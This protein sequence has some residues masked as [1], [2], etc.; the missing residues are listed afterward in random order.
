MRRTKAE[1]AATRDSII[2]AAEH[3][4]LNQ[5][6]SQTTLAQIAKYAGVTRGAIYFHFTDKTEIFRAII[7]KIRFP[8]ES[9]I[10]EAQKDDSINPLDILQKSAINAFKQF[11]QDEQQ[12]R[13]VTIITQRCEYVGAFSEMVER[14]RQAQDS[15]LDL[16]IRLLHVAKDRNMLNSDFSPENAA[17]M[18]VAIVGGL[19][20]EWLHS[21]KAFDLQKIGEQA[22]QT[23]FL[24]L[25]NQSHI[26]KKQ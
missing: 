10:E 2:N 1:A 16:F 17:R 12:Q 24:A 25:H 21:S 9:L 14:L 15:M 20:S 3:L 13:V 26:S 18:L 7:Q 23:Q 5:G 8:Q 11:S 6:V 4:F 19:I 22:L